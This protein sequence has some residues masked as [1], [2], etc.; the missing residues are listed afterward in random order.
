M[1]G[2][3][4]RT[5]VHSYDDAN[6]RTTTTLANGL[7][8]TSTYDRAGRLVSVSDAVTSQALGTTTYQYDADGRLRITTDPTGVKSFVLYDEAGRPVAAK[9]CRSPT[10]KTGS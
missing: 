5:S 4:S 8:T 3:T 10:T 9:T 1:N 2:T 6:R 7:A